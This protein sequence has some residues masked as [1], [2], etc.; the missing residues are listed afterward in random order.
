MPS[1]RIFAG[2]ELREE[3]VAAIWEQVDGVLAAADSMALC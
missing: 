3:Q 2:L 1:T